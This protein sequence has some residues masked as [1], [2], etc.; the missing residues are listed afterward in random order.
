[1]PTLQSRGEV[2]DSKSASK[3]REQERDGRRER[4]IGLKRVS[5]KAE[6]RA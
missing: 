6:V 2:Q 4:G 3:V 5:S 1:M